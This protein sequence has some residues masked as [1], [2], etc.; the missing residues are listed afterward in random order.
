MEV[1][2]SFI[3]FSSVFFILF[4]SHFFGIYSPDF[5]VHSLFRL[6]RFRPRL[7][8]QSAVKTVSRRKQTMI[9]RHSIASMRSLAIACLLSSMIAQTT[10]QNPTGKFKSL[11]KQKVQ[12]EASTRLV[13]MHSYVTGISEW[14]RLSSEHGGHSIRDRWHRRNVEGNEFISSSIKLHAESRGQMIFVV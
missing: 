5:H 13:S 1:F 6:F 2:L 8:P 3:F 12:Q 9:I 4:L 10:G 7:I 14:Q 11:V